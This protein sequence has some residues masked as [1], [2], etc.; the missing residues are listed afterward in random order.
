[1]HLSLFHRIPTLNDPEIEDFRNILG[2]G[3][4]ADYQHFLLFPQCLLPVQWQILF[5]GH[6]YFVVCE[7]FQ[8]EPDKN[9]IIC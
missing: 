3:E 2:K 7:C 1:M 4:N 5:F 6:I 8:F 9:F